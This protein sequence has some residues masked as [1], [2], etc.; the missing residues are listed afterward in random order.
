[1]ENTKKKHKTLLLACGIPGS[2]KS[3]WLAQR[4]DIDVVSRDTI[5]FAV[6]RDGDD[7]FSKEDEVIN[8]FFHFIRDS[9]NELRKPAMVC[10]DATHL[11]PKA[12]AK[13]LNA[14]G[15]EGICKIIALSFETPLSV[16]LER[17]AGRTGRARVPDSV[18]KN[19]YHSFVRP[20]LAEGFD[21]IW[22]I[23]ENG[24]VVKEVCSNE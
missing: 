8:R 12:R 7:Y 19:M 21:E 4:P 6:L 18:I 17:N 3:T 10:A 15:P 16:A 23:D 14:I 5:R 11:T 13:T 9:I 20:T 2:G 24:N 1:M 22:H